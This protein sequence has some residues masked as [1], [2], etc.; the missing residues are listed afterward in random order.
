[1][2]ADLRVVIA[3][4]ERDFVGDVDLAG[5]GLRYGALGHEIVGG[6][7]SA[8]LGKGGEPVADGAFCVPENGPSA[9]P[10]FGGKAGEARFSPCGAVGGGEEC[11]VVHPERGK[12]RGGESA[13]FARVVGYGCDSLDRAFCVHRHGGLAPS[14][15]IAV[16]P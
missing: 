4:D 13:G 8:R 12:L 14:A 7:Q 3:A 2:F 11:E 16:Q 10:D 15:E 5:D 9:P 6:E 1:M